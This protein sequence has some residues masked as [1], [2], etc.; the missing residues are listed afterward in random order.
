MTVMGNHYGGV[1]GAVSIL[2]ADAR[3]ASGAVMYMEVKVMYG[4][5]MCN[6]IGNQDM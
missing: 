5:N 1:Y 6:R 4:F 3:D 2:C